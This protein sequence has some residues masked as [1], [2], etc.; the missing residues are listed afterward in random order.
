MRGW[1]NRKP[2]DSDL[3]TDFDRH[4]D[5]STVD[6]YILWGSR[7]VIL[8]VGREKVIEAL[9]KTHPGIVKMKILARNYVWWLKMDEQLELKVR[10][11]KMCQ[12]NQKNPQVA[13]LN[14]WKWPE[15][16]WVRLHT[17]YAGPFM[18]YMYL[19]VIDSHSKWL[20]VLP[21]LKATSQSKVR[22]MKRIFVIH[23]LPDEI[24]TGNGTSFTG[25]EFQQSV[26]QNGI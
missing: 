21:V 26:T 15:E 18:E 16:L 7:I 24:V 20:D 13:P 4:N 6:G 8:K 19:I 3:I 2:N 1:P 14:P 5:L 12:C 17:D 22:K 9:H 11:C 10:N 23:R 25:T